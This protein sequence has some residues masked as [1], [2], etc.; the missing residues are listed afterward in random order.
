MVVKQLDNWPVYKVQCLPTGNQCNPTY[1]I[2]HRNCLMLVPSEDDTA[3]DTTQLLA[4][5]AIILNACMGTLLNEVDDG[6]VASEDEAAPESVTPSLLTSSRRWSNP[7]CM[8]ERQISHPAL[9][10]DGE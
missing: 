2:L 10:S 7:T 3:S 9:H 5:A 8:V 1:W 6:D 4:L